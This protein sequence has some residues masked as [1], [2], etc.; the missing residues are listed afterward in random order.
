MCCA[1]LAH[2]HLSHVRTSCA[3]SAHGYQSPW[4]KYRV[5]GSPGT[6]HPGEVASGQQPGPSLCSEGQ[7][8]ARVLGTHP[9]QHD[10]GHLARRAILWRCPRQTHVPGRSRASWEGV[11]V[12]GYVSLRVAPRVPFARRCMLQAHG[13]PQMSAAPSR[14]LGSS[15]AWC[16]GVCLE[17]WVCHGG[18]RTDTCRA[19]SSWE[20]LAHMG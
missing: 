19:H 10:H 18:H 4:G 8:L 14:V 20:V 9:S 17:P 11:R 16:V 15:A 5:S 1:S 6:R 3:P 2:S 13:C 12:R 7:V